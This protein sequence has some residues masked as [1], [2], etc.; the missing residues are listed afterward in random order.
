MVG[1][2]DFPNSWSSLWNRRGLESSSLKELSGFAGGMSELSDS[3]LKSIVA[4]LHKRT[5]SNCQN[6][7][8]QVIEIGSGAGRFA[9]FWKNECPVR[10]ALT[11]PQA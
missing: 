9:L 4:D 2:S 8:S 5:H 10:F 7:D 6:N 3:D 1:V 11:R